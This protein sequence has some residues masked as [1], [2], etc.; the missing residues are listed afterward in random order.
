M[1]AV[2]TEAR[3]EVLAQPGS[4]GLGRINHQWDNAPDSAPQPASDVGKQQFLHLGR[5]NV[6]GQNQ[7]GA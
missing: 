1:R 4:L 3:T 2:V 6:F 5:V 7:V